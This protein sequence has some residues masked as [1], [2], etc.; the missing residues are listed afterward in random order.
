WRV[1]REC[2]RPRSS[3]TLSWGCETGVVY[4]DHLGDAAC[5]RNGYGAV[6]CI[7]LGRCVFGRTGRAWRRA[8]PSRVCLLPWRQTSG[9]GTHT[10]SGWFG[11]R[12]ELERDDD[13]RPVRQDTVVHAR[14]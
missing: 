4:K 14:R 10:C 3:I 13:R 6:P 11:L 8:L 7:G 1:R 2:P 12:N 9:Q 5:V